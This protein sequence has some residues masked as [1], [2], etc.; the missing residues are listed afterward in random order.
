MDQTTCTGQP[1]Q[2]R[3]LIVED[4]EPSRRLLRDIF[5]QQG[6]CI[7]EAV[8][9]EAALDAVDQSPPDVILLDIMI[10]RLD[11]LEVC[12]RLKASPRTA[13]TPILLVT[14]LHE[15]EDRLR[16][17]SC[18]ANDFIS[19]PIDTDEVLLRV[20]NALRMKRAFDQRDHLLR[21]RE[22]LSDM[23]VHDI[24]NPLVAIMLVAKKLASQ[25]PSD[26]VRESANNILG[27]VDLIERFIEDLLDVSQMEQDSIKLSLTDLDLTELIPVVLEN[28]R[29]QAEQKLIALAFHPPAT[30]CPVRVDKRLLSRLLDNLLA[31]AIKFSPESGCVS[32]SVLAASADLPVCRIVVEDDGPGVPLHFRETIFDKYSVVE[33]EGSPVRQTGLGL[34]FCKLAAQAHGGRISV[35]SRQPHGSAFVV[36]LP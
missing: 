6:Y 10:P 33:A 18:G 30:P 15:R 8:D 5:E 28:H 3:L 26:Q 4:D 31:N 25:K 7:S 14:A 23:I 17:I 1:A 29:H 19:K 11:G 20:R 22:D 9:G 13:Q 21:L 24:R 32:V 16:G 35:V 27:Q 12:R 36:E 2:G 34:T